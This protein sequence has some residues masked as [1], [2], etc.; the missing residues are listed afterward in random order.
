MAPVGPWHLA[1]ASAPR[2]R[3]SSRSSPPWPRPR[4]STTG[5]VTM[6]MAFMVFG[7]RRRDGEPTGARR[8]AAAAGRR[9]GGWCRRSASCRSDGDAGAAAAVSP[10]RPRS[11][12]A[13]AP[14]VDAHLPRWRRPSLMEARKADPT[15]DGHAG[16]AAHLRRRLAGA[17]DGM[18]RRLI[19]YRLVR[20][21]DAP[22]RAPR[23]GDRLAR[24]G[25]RGRPAR[26]ARHVLARAVPGRPR[27]LAPQDDAGRRRDRR[28]RRPGRQLDRGR[29]RPDRRRRSRTC[30]APTRSSRRQFGEA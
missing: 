13:A 21:L 16:V 5:G 28:R 12:S 14:D 1:T 7:K 17:V 22:G 15:A 11:R 29:Q 2:R 30:C 8:G 6:A 18:E 4:S 27:G 24:R 20:L 23:H 9:G 3:A 10:S 19:R 26:E 25:R